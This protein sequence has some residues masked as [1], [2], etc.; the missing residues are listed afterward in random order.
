MLQNDFFYIK[1]LEN[2]DN[3]VHAQLE[4]NAA[5]PVFEGHFPEQPVVPGVCMV[6]MIK[7]VLEQVLNQSLQLKAADHIKFLS[8]VDPRVSPLMQVNISYAFPGETLNVVASLQKEEI[9]C[10]KLKGHYAV[11]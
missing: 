1:S 2:T 9:V 10:L 7:E 6:Q 8:V 5:H 11:V 4:L 3:K